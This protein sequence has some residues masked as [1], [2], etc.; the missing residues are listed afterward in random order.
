M[1]CK[2]TLWEGGVRGVGL[3]WSPLLKSSARVHRGLVNVQDWLPTFLSAANQSNPFPGKQS[4]Q[5]MRGLSFR[6]SISSVYVSL[7]SRVLPNALIDCHESSFFLYTICMRFFS[8]IILNPLNSK[9]YSLS[10]SY[11]QSQ[12][13][14]YP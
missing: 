3:I 13:M 9:S 11:F 8:F 4:N 2:D 1:Q 6:S 10:V 14:P 5:A 12:F 7:S